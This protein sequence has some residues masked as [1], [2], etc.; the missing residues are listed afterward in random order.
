MLR[1]AT[2]LLHAGPRRLLPAALL[3][4]TSATASASLLDEVNDL[5]VKGCG[6]RT[7][8]APLKPS[9]DLDAVAKEW[10]K[11]GR[12][13]DALER[14]NYRAL[15]SASMRIEGAPNQRAL[16]AAL[17][18]NYC[19]T[20]INPEFTTIGISQKSKDVHIVVALPFA[21]PNIRETNAL[22]AQVLALVN[23]ARRQPRKC[24]S[25]SY[26]AASPLTLSALLNRTALIHAQDMAKHNFFEHQGSDGS[27]VATRA[28]KVGYVWR[29]IGE[30][31]AAGPTT[32]ETVVKGWLN[33]PGHCA[34]IMGQ[35]F[36][37][38]GI[39]FATDPKSDAGIYWAQVLGSSR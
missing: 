18:K 23:D 10:S 6:S 4:L 9:R 34:N 14:T 16:L 29:S 5:R 38:M 24:G 22:A 31:I 15:N 26:A 1:L 25:K 19:E 21:A 12:L 20:L 17:A 37:E 39:A 27:T 33:R 36:T 32:A 28:T 35:S 8:L 7:A 2:H 11:G 3:L 30:N 13:R